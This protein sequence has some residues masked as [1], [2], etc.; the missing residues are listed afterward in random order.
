MG[1]FWIILKKKYKEESDLIKIM[2]KKDYDE[3]PSAEEI[4]GNSIFKELGKI[5][6]K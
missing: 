5:V 2:T 3:R 6:N 1:K 4:L